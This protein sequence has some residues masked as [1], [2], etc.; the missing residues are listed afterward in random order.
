MNHP[1]W[2]L[3]RS[4][5]VALV[6]S[7]LGRVFVDRNVGDLPAAELT[8]ELDDELYALNQRLGDRATS[9]RQPAGASPVR[10]DAKVPGS[11]APG[12]G[13]EAG[14]E[15]GPSNWPV[16]SMKRSLQRRKDLPLRRGK[17]V[18]SLCVFG[19]GHGSRLRTWSGRRR[20]LR[21]RGRGTARRV[22]RELE[23]PYS[24]PT[25][26]ESGA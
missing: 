17:T 25:L 2:A 4:N 10:G 7:F 20:T 14:V 11:R 12:S 18:P 16:R 1:A 5:N 22:A 15:A 3:L 13:R 21:R 8:G 23:R 24:A 19:E 6:L 26:R 9:S